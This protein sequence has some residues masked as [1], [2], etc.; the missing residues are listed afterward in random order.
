MRIETN[1]FSGFTWSRFFQA[2]LALAFLG[3][4]SGFVA[5]FAG[6]GAAAGWRVGRSIFGP[7]CL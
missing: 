5:G 6:A 4:A 2:L 3:L 1:R 7:E